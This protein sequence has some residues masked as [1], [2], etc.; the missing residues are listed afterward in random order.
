MTG[1]Q[2][3]ALPISE[4]DLQTWLGSIHN[5]CETRDIGRLVVA[6]KEIVLDYNPSTHLLKR[7]LQPQDRHAVPV[8][9]MI[10]YQ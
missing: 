7:I 4:D 10:P 6:L 5:I 1:V 9:G 2:T 8:I 3:C